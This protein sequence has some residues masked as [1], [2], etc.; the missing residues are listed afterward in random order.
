LD[1]GG[2]TAARAGSG[3]RQGRA[4]VVWVVELKLGTDSPA[5]SVEDEEA[6]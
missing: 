6:S 3:L 2:V 5:P 4:E 1:S